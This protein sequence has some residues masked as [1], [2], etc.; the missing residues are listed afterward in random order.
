MPGKQPV[1][2]A[3]DIG[4]GSARAVLFD[5]AAHH[6]AQVGQRYEMRYPQPGWNEQDPQVV[7]GAV[8][9]VLRQAVADLPADVALEGIV[10]SAQMYSVLALDA[11]GEPR[12][13]SLTWGDT[14]SAQIAAQIRRAASAGLSAR[15]GCPIQAIYPLS[16]IRWLK[17]NLDLPDDTRFVSI[18]DYVVWRLTG[19]L[20]SDWSIASASG[21]LD[22]S[23]CGWDPEAL[24][25]C[26]ISPH[27][28]P[29]LVSTRYVI[30]RWPPE[31]SQ[32]IGIRADLPLILGA[33]DAPLANIGV[34]A[35]A[36]GTMAVNL[37]TSAAARVLLTEPHVDPAGQLWTY[38]ADAGH[39]TMGGIIGSGGAVYDWLLR[40][41]LFK[42]QALSADELFREAD[43]L[44]ASVPP[45]AGGLLFVPYFSGEQSPGW[46]SHMRGAMYGM[47]L[48]QETRHHIRAA[49]EGIVFSLLR[50]AK[51][52]ERLTEQQRGMAAQKIYLTGGLAASPVWSQII[53]DVFGASVVVPPSPESSA[54]GAAILGWL[55]LGMADNYAAFAQPESA[56]ESA[57]QP[58]P[59][60]HA[61]YQPRY[62]AFSSLIDHLRQF[63][64]EQEHSHD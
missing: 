20:V 48:G 33:G 37:G 7:V 34:G 24:A 1:I 8:L 31:I 18:K 38:V 57:R 16:K 27:N 52:T 32:Y 15:T 40:D 12:S 14:R 51:L 43:R 47:A 10:L 13:Y 62:A 4:T 30:R 50:V 61:F 6:R 29:E 56:A 5:A 60:M 23:R 55:A 21:L 53:A 49:I 36:P 64:A 25:L 58:D 3:V 22:I 28:L 63:V 42:G 39:W 19:E 45:G 11:R 26:G 59:A 44:A 35:I 46:N 2:L 54:R 17:H 9:D 41:L